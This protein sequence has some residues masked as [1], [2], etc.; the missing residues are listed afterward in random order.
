MELG[1]MV[2][3]TDNEPSYWL[4]GRW[5]GGDFENGYGIVVYSRRKFYI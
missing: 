1:I 4:D 5:N 3:Q 2:Y